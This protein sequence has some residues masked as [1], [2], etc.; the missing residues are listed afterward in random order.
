MKKLIGLAL[1]MFSMM[2]AVAPVKAAQLSGA[3]ISL[4]DTGA[5]ASTTHSFIF[6][7]VASIKTLKSVSFQYCKD[8]SGGCVMPTSMHTT[9]STLGTLSGGVTT[10][11]WDMA[12][13]V[14]GTV[15]FTSSQGEVIAAST[16]VV[17]QA[18]AITNPAIGDC[19][20]TTGNTSDTCYV[21]MNAYTSSDYTGTPD[22][23][24]ASITVSAKVT[25]SARVD[26]TFT[27]VVQSTAANSVHGAI[28]TSVPT[29]FS[30]LPFGNL[31]ANVPKYAAH[32]LYVTTNTQ[33][34]YSV[35][36]AMTTAMTGSY[37]SNNIDPFIASWGSPVSS[38]TSPT[39]T[40]P[41]DNTG[42]FAA[43]TTD[44]DVWTSPSGKFAGVGSSPVI[45]M[46]SLQSDNGQ[47]PV[48]VTYA[49]EA[50]VFQP[51]DSYSGTLV[52][53]AVPTY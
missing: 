29:T 53:S 46:S 35:T 39:G 26:P 8:P 23:T 28:T 41:N 16:G 32:A 20:P 31:T 4:L 12:H 52:Y 3:K 51:A 42:W 48:Y 1:F 50:N 14:D 43:N 2:V 37:T 33:N 49:V 11:N 45:V 15:G 22:T 13:P 30:T 9:G 36:A 44:A 18:G 38:W 17:F 10:A 24:I 7:T 27:F 21:I 40:V 25:V 5:T 47:T 34:G 6:T 19:H